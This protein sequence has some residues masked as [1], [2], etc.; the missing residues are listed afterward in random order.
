MRN[1]RLT[2][3]RRLLAALA[4]PAG[5]SLIA[6]AALA[7]CSSGASSGSADNVLNAPAASAS[8]AAPAGAPAAG[9]AIPS[10]EATPTSFSVSDKGSGSGGSAQSTSARLASTGQIIYTAQLKVRAHSVPAAVTTATSIVT[11]AGGYVSAENAT[12]DPSHPASASATI[13]V[14]IPVAVYAST[15][16]QLSTVLGTQLALQQQAQDVTEQVA[17]VN[18]R[19]ASDEAGIAQLRVLLRHA[20]SVADLLSVQDQINSQESD[21]EAL[22]AQ[23]SALSHETSYATVTVTVIGPKAAAKPVKHKA[24]P[25]FTSGISGGWRAFR[26]SVSWFLAIIGAVA[27]FAAVVAVLGGLAYWARRR[28]SQRRSAA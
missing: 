15:L 16:G 25:G 20:G 4:V 1:S 23:Q 21:L 10:P 13:V 27:P 26:T 2:A 9:E 14:K 17:D 22:Q 3:H 11:G 6:M 8:A 24:P 18:S 19:V 5:L 12:S 7:S 28:R